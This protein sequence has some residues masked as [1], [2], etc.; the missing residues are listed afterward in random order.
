[1]K[2]DERELRSRAGIGGPGVAIIAAFLYYNRAKR[3]PANGDRR[4]R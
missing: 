2:W 3:P 4:R 1:M